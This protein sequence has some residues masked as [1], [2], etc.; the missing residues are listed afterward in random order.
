MSPPF[1]ID[2]LDLPNLP[3]DSVMESYFE[4]SGFLDPHHLSPS[5]VDADCPLDLLDDDNSSF[6]SALDAVGYS[7]MHLLHSTSVPCFD[8][9]F[10][11]AHVHALAPATHALYALDLWL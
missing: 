3:V 9:E 8:T 1:Q 10:L 4:A 6:G 7:S 5:D 2:F 11:H